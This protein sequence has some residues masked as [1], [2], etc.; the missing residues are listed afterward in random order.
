MKKQNNKGFSLVELIVVVAIMAVLMGILVPTLI[1]YVQQSKRQKDLSALEEYRA[2]MQ[3][4][5]VSDEDYAD[6]SGTYTGSDH[7]DI[8]SMDA[9]IDGD[10][11]VVSA[12][13]DDVAENID[14][15]DISSKLYKGKEIVFT[16][17]DGKNVVCT[18]AG[19]NITEIKAKN[20][21]LD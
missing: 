14:A 11:D 16:L 13:Q 19:K 5:L 2:A 17:E 8:T 20:K 12:Y 9:E 21:T 18:L 15:F 3:E 4:V 10:S 1:K 6:L 7:I